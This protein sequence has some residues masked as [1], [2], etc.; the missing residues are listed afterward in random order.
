MVSAALVV[1]GPLALIGK[2]HLDELEAGAD[3]HADRLAELIRAVAY[4]DTL[5]RALNKLSEEHI[6]LTELAGSHLVDECRRE[7][8]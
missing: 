8:E 6:R 5:Q 7:L 2:A 3:A 4:A 1:I